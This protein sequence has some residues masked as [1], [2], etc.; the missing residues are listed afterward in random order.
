[1]KK[2]TKKIFSVILT[3]SIVLGAFPTFFAYASPE[4]MELL[5]EDI[6]KATPTLE[7][8]S[9]VKVSVKGVSGKV[10]NFQVK[11][12]FSGDLKYTGIEYLTGKNDPD[13][14]CVTFTPDTSITNISKVMTPFIATNSKNA[15][16]FSPEGQELFILTFKGEGGKSGEISAITSPDETFCVTDEKEYEAEKTTPC[17]FTAG[18][19]TVSS[20]D[21]TVKLIMDKVTSF[22][23]TGGSEEYKDS[24]ITLTIISETSG[25]TIHTTLNDIPKIEG[26]HRESE[27]IPTFTV[28]N[29]VL[30]EDTYTVKVAGDGYTD[31][32]ITG[33]TFD[34]VIEITNAQLIPGDLNGDNKV[35]NKDKVLMEKAIDAESLSDV[36][37]L[38]ENPNLNRDNRVDS[39]D[40][41]ILESVMEDNEIVPARMTAPTVSGGDRKIT[42]KWVKPE[43]ESV[44]GYVV[45]Y[46]DSANNLDKTKEITG[47]DV[48]ETEI[49][50]LS[51]DTWYYV[52]V[53]AKNAKGVGE[54]SAMESAKTD[55]TGGG[56]GGGFGGPI[57][58]NTN[59]DNQNQENTGAFN[60]LA[61]YDWAKDAIYK[62]KDLGIISGTSANTYSPAKNIERGD[63]IL[64]LTRMLKLENAFEENF[65]DVPA[66]SYYYDAI[67]KA[68]AIGIATGDGINFKPESSITRQDLI[69]LSYRAFLNA[70]YILEE[71]ETTVLEQFSDMAAISEYALIPLASMVKAGIIKGSGSGVNPKGLATRAEVAV[72]CQRLYE[73]LK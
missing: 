66:G 26:G 23:A 27:V 67:G 28:T 24:G 57:G 65:A 20:K 70:G 46:G 9:K 51:A 36:E 6:T 40:L 2:I 12:A 21:A 49:T 50:D 22:A 19:Q 45:K 30:S 31:Y 29:T 39:K 62:L 8:E 33:V 69:T 37:G 44:T 53:A 35:D 16:E 58:G 13:N 72:M 10:K 59:K 11:L 56:G 15:I 25:Y 55:S 54:M 18:T 5:I 14:G 7:G 71:S 34:N 4:K 73:L 60:D 32:E 48:L 68:K 41:A 42:V 63:F 3:C 52:T 17:K 61:G 64:I 38:F 47:K 1:M 43:D